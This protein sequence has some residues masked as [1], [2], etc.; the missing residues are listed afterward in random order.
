MMECAGIVFATLSTMLIFPKR[1]VTAPQGPQPIVALLVAFAVAVPLVSS[2]APKRQA[3]VSMETVTTID[4]HTLPAPKMIDVS[5]V[6]LHD[7]PSADPSREKV[8]GTIINDGDRSVSRIA[9]R[10]NA[11]DATG[12]VVRTV[13]TPPLSQTIDPFGG[14]ATFE[15]FMPRDPAVAGYHAVAIAQ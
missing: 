4:E 7:E 8:V 12:N 14:R 1:S 15:T 10:V 13:T 5:I 11:L 3:V 9:I 6:N 2:C